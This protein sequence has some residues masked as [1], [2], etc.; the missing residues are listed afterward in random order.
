MQ[1]FTKRH[2]RYPDLTGKRQA[3]GGWRLT[4][5]PVAGTPDAPLVS[6]VTVCFN[7]AATIEQTLR[8]VQAQTY[9]A[10]EHIVVDGASTDGTVDILRRH[11][12]KLAYYVS[13]PDDGLYYAMNKG[14][15]LAQGDY[16]LLLNADDWY[17]PEAVAKL[18]AAKDYSG[19]DF[20]AALARYVDEANGKAEILR[21]MP[22][23][24]SALLRMSLRHETMLVP[25]ALYD[26][27]G[28]Y[29]T[30]YRIIADRHLTARLYEAGATFYEL[31]EALLNFRTTGL[32]NSNAALLNAEQVELL[33]QTFPTLSAEECKALSDGGT[34]GPQTFA[35]IAKRHPEDPKFARAARALLKDRR[36]HGG[37]RWHSDAAETI[38]AEG[39]G[40][41]PKVSVILPFHAAEDGIAASL[42]S[43]LAQSLTD[44]EIVCVNDCA[45]DGSQAIVD[46]YMARDSRVRCIRN[47]R[48]LGLGASRNAGIRA[49]K[50]RYVFHL[51]PDDTIPPDALKT[52]YDAAIA[53][54]GDMVKGAY[55]AA[56][57]LHGQDGGAA[58]VKFPAGISDRIVART[59]LTQTPGLLHTTEGHWSYLYDADFA[60]RVPYPTDLK[61]GQDSIFLVRAVSS[62]KA[63]TLVPEIVYHYEANPMSAMNRFN[64][65]K[66]ND[67]LEWRRRAWHVLRDAGHPE[68]ADRLLFRYWNPT[69]FDNLDGILTVD[70]RRAFHEKLGDALLEAG[71]PGDNPPS[72]RKLRQRFEAA[73]A[74][75]GLIRKTSSSLGRP[76]GIATIITSDHGGAGIGSLRRVEALRREGHDAEIHCL[77][78][79]TGLPYVNSLPASLSDGAPIPEDKTHEAWREAAVLSRSEEPAL[80][81]SELFSKTGA[82]VDFRAARPVFE[83]ADIVHLHWVSGV[84]DY[85]NADQLADRPVVWTLAD[86]NA[87]TG[88]CHY[89]EGCEGYRHEC[90]DCPLL[91]GGS[92]LAH[93]NWQT[94][95]DAYAKI[96]DLHVICPSQWLADRARDSALLG[97]RPVHMIPNALPVRRFTPTNRLAARRR[98]GLP[99]NARLVAFGADNLANRRKGGDILRD[100][101]GRLK[102]MGKADGVEGLFFG[103]NTLDLG[104]P[105]HSMGH[106]SDEERMSLIYAA[107]DVFAFPSRE[108]NAPL[109]VA[110]ALLSGTPV[111]GFP[112]GN[113][114]ELVSHLDTGYIAAYEDAADFARGLAWALEA[115]NLPATLE[116]RLRG[117]LKARRHNDP[118]IA[119]ARH[120]ALYQ[121]L[122]E[123][124]A[125]GS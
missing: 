82:V 10:I 58:T 84:L 121:T 95:R 31:P 63:I 85:E 57:G 74:R 120:I 75:A 81:A 43:V 110:E 114:P 104:I 39:A 90:R 32:S 72:D 61:M 16:I 73:T 117:H 62:A 22:F 9:G 107:A 40:A 83:A 15:E 54:G 24:D 47:P 3:E 64:A 101:V 12:D 111:V 122:L 30:R 77:F 65:R 44:I 59:D 78:R 2:Y 42:E 50:G 4:G 55:R 113:V 80:S 99:L 96:P 102:K 94:K 1:H 49:A 26:R 52:L 97:D 33:A 79:K 66:F 51:D 46:T 29:D 36:V 92:D 25:A 70:E 124:R 27:V 93:R 8:S 87:F 53:H 7:A 21:P 35:D 115:P 13:E 123:N 41:W 106:I 37:K 68:L 103:A 20:T 67:A 28:P 112:V 118:D 109:T 89:S 19:C 45:V 18:V 48:N 69:F 60:R 5:Q 71:Y 11:E 34:A 116:R 56:Q 105:A 91:G 86:M 98:L 88:G 76:L 23:D 100:A 119:V 6:V 38:G 14:L 17:E 108:D 125:T